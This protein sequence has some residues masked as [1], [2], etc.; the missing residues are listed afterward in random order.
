M[1]SQWNSDWVQC[2]SHSLLDESRRHGFV[3]QLL[4]FRQSTGILDH[5]HFELRMLFWLHCGWANYGEN[6]TE[7]DTFDLYQCLLLFGVLGHFLG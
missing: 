2:S 4:F 3:W 1:F 7:E 6:W 5:G